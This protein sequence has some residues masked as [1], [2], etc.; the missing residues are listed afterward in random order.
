[1]PYM[2]DEP[3]THKIKNICKSHV[4]MSSKIQLV[5]DVYKPLCKV[6]LK[7]LGPPEIPKKQIARTSTRIASFTTSFVRF[8]R[9]EVSALMAAF[10]SSS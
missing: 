7:L 9:C 6:V 2:R 1:M 4:L 10:A 3:V 5:Q 8:A